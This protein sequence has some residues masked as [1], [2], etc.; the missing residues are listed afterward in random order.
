MSWVTNAY[1]LTF[2]GFLLSGA[3]AGDILG[4]RLMF[5]IGLGIFVVSSLLI[6]AARTPEWLIIMRAA[7]GV[8]SAI[9]APSTLALLQTNFAPGPGRR[10]AIS[11]YA[12]AAGVSASF[13]LVL[14]GILADWLSWRVGF[15]INLPI[16]AALMVAAFRYFR[17]TDRRSGT[18]DFAGALTSTAGII[19]LVFGIVR[20]ISS[21][22]ND[23]ATLEVMVAAILL[24]TTF[25]IIEWRA[26]QP[27]MP[28][29]LFAS[30]ERSGAYAARVL[31]LGA[32]VGFFFF[33]TQFMQGVLGLTP[34][35][36]G[37]PFFPPWS[38]TS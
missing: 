10:R 15:F 22:W 38:R 3:R 32:N 9:L 8:G 5:I 26:R 12:S 14:G 35:R 11:Y 27:I 2:G 31:F 30:R 34:T 24:L 36:P 16:G 23:V 28:L 33:S 18:F 21:G 19:L 29:R 4:R 20:S 13:G 7:Q 37:W 17:E 1:L 6:G 25:V